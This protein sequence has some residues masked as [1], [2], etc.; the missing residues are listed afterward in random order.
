MLAE[1]GYTALA[2]DMYGDGRQ[3]AHPDDAQKFV[4]ETIRNLDTAKARFMAAYD[5]LAKQESVDPERIGAIGYC[6]GGGVVLAMAREGV[7]LKGVASFHG[8]LGTPSPAERG[9]VKARILVCNGAADPFVTPE[10]IEQFKKEMLDAGVDAKFVN[11][12]GA[13]HAFTN[14]EADMFGKKFGLPLAYNKDADEQSWKEMQGFFRQ[15]F[16]R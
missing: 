9:K 6:F 7:G 5:L 4:M 10:Q 8:S 13:L 11:Y 1:L 15:V 12:P 3:A 2:V 14:P 16:A